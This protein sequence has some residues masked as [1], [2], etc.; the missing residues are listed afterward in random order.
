ML[1]KNKTLTECQNYVSPISKNDNGKR[2]NAETCF[3]T[4][5]SLH[6]N[7]NNKYN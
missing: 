1:G 5:T 7:H 4:F 3:Y 2:Q 6:R